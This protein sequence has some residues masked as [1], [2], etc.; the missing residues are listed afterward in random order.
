MKGESRFKSPKS[1]GNISAKVG[2]YNESGSDLCGKLLLAV[3][4]DDSKKELVSITINE[5]SAENGKE[6]VAVTSD[7]KFESLDGYIAKA[8]LFDS[9][10]SLKPMCEKTQNLEPIS[11]DITIW[12]VWRMQK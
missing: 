1:A 2:I 9:F 10:E 12:N 5:V 11:E 4:K 3:Y 6:T 8:M 7:I